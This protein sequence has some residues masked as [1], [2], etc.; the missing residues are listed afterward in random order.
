MIYVGVDDTDAPGVPG[1][2]K[3]ARR[4]LPRL[5]ACGPTFGITRHQLLVDPRIRYTS[6]NSSAAIMLRNGAARP[7]D[8]IAQA[9]RRAL[10]AGCAEGS[11]PAF[12]VAEEV[13]AE[14]TAFGRRAQSEVLNAGEALALAVRCGLLLESV[15]G[16]GSGVVGALAAVGLAAAGD[17]GRF[18]QLGDWPDDL[19]GRQPARLLRRRGV[20]AF[21]QEGGRRSVEPDEVDVG[22]RLRPNYRG[23][24]VALYVREGA[25][26]WQAVR[27]P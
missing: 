15:A 21:I 12:C 6:K 18:V 1:T 9:L 2:N 7:A 13:A 5:R 3:L 19:S 26:G 24:R 25:A 10:A 11:D 4:I 23:G 22:K 8:G 16:D 14:V 17:D 27:H 20:D